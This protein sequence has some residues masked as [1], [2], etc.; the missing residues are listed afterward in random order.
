MGLR[1]FLCLKGLGEKSCLSLENGFLFFLGLGVVI[2]LISSASSSRKMTEM[3][4][5]VLAR[6]YGGKTETARSPTGTRATA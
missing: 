1:F 3:A 6:M 2:E 5:K 4:L